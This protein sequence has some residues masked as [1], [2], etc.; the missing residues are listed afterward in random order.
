MDQLGLT[1]KKAGFD[2][3]AIMP[4]VPL[5]RMLPILKEAQTKGRYPAFVDKDINKRINPLALQK[6]AQS[7]ISL[8]V[9]Y[10]TKDPGPTPPLH[11]T[12]SR[13][14]WG[15]DYHHVLNERMDV[16]ISYL[17][18]HFSAQKCTKAADTSFLIDRA[19]AIEAG[20]GYPGANCAVY[21]PPYGSWVFLGAIL[22]DVKLPFTK[23]EGESNWDNPV[24]CHTC[25]QACPTNALL[26]PGK[27]NPMRC[28]SH[29]TQ[30]SG[31]IP[32]E[33]RDK[34]GM[35]LWGCDNCQQ[36]CPENRHAK[37]SPHEEFQPLKSPHIPLLPLLTM[38]NREFKKAFGL[39]AMAWRGKNILQ[40][41]ACIV[42]GNQKNPQ[43][44][45]TLKKVYQK[46]PS[47]MVQEAALWALDKI[48]SYL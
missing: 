18:K 5:Q 42:L 20:L 25:M 41:N 45:P 38:S 7:I 1:I 47:E 24:E 46:H 48:N 4:A 12:V 22:V 35:R 23:K 26:A 6:S 10:Y 28:I 29:L 44:V 15:R 39:T 3:Y 40:R 13:Y 30:M 2:A 17:Q 27:I 34:M 32:L 36:A 11:G 21:V 9:S 16:V 33:L 14:A 8:A 37:K 19:I 43:A 31:S